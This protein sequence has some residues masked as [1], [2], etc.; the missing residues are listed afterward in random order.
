MKEGQIKMSEILTN[1]K[2]LAIAAHPD[3]LE[4][5][6]FGALTKFKSLGNEIFLLILSKGEKKDYGE[7]RCEESKQSASVLGATLY[8]EELKDSSIAYDER[9]ISLIE[10]YIEKIKPDIIFAPFS[11]DSH[12][13]HRNSFLSI[14]SASRKKHNL[15]CYESVTSMNFDPNIFFDITE[16]MQTKIKCLS[17]HKSQLKAAYL[18]EEAIKG[19]ALSYGFK[20]GR[21]GKYFEGAKLIRLIY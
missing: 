5:G 15:L 9:T 18:V 6:C 20:L 13:D 3:D 12:Q 14:L 4:I 10:G 17:C 21:P 8:L 16:H 1:G 7:I 11:E 19:S 2:V